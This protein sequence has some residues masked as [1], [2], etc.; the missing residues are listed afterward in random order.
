MTCERCVRETI[1]GSLRRYLKVVCVIEREGCVCPTT[2][3]M[4]PFPL[5]VN[6]KG[7]MIFTPYPVSGYMQGGSDPFTINSQFAFKHP[8]LN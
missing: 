7:A 1:R 6:M 8:Q 4:D 3:E 2:V 5:T